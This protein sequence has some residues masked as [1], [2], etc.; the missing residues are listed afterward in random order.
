MAQARTTPRGS[1][2]EVKM[3]AGRV[4]KIPA[5]PFSGS[6][7]NV[8]GSFV[9]SIARKQL[10]LAVIGMNKRKSIVRLIRVIALVGISAASLLHPLQ[11]L[12]SRPLSPSQTVSIA[13]M[14]NQDNQPVNEAKR[15]QRLKELPR[16][17]AGLL[18]AFSQEP[19]NFFL[20]DRTNLRGQKRQPLLIQRVAKDKP[21]LQQTALL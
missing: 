21:A 10:S 6:D 2:E 12:T 1:N 11:E 17:A 9:S 7:P 20:H 19:C 18:I 8:R 5:L 3:R 15:Q 14:V 4:F 13:H 16:N